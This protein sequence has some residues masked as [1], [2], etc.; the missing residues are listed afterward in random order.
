MGRRFSAGNVTKNG[1]R[2]AH[3]WDWQGPTSKGSGGL[4][5]AVHGHMQHKGKRWALADLPRTCHWRDESSPV[6]SCVKLT[7]ASAL[8]AST[9]QWTSCW[10]WKPEQ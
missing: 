2:D 3:V 6:K 7:P 4:F 9:M 5:L 8:L 10:L 1:L